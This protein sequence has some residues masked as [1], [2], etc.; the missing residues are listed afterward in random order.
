MNNV[1]YI[2]DNI[3][4][5]QLSRTIDIMMERGHIYIDEKDYI[6]EKKLVD[7]QCDRFISTIVKRGG[8]SFVDLMFAF[9]TTGNA[10]VA[11]TINRSTSRLQSG[12]SFLTTVG[13]YD[14]QL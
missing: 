9:K 11:D 8:K 4:L 12:D 3:T 7:E 1:I 5:P 14:K 6:T 13:M 2:K 10:H